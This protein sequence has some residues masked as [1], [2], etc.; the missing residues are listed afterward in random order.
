MK[1]HIRHFLAVTALASALPFAAHAADVVKIGVAGPFTG[2]N[3]AFGEQLWI[4]AT[5]AADAINSK[6]GINGKKIELIKADDACEPK[7]AVAVA[8]RL[9]D[10]D[11]V[12]AVVGHFCSSSTIPAS[13][14]YDDADILSMA[15]GSTNP[16]VTERGLP[17]VTRICGRDDQQARVVAA[18]LANNLKTKRIAVIHDKDTYGRGVADATREEAKRLGVETVLYDGVTRGERDFNALVTKIKAADVDAV[19]FGGLYAEA[20]TLARQIREQ[21]LTIPYVSDDGIVDPAFVTAAGGKQFAK[22]VYMSFP[23]DPRTLPSSKDI[24]AKLTQE[25]KKADGFVLYAY[26]A[27]EAVA[28]AI[29]ATDS[30]S[31]TELADWLKKN[32]VAT[33]LGDKEWD[34]KGDLTVPS[35]VMYQWDADGNYAELA[36]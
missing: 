16:E 24:V 18:F 23:A 32:K 31:G 9:V 30:V 1:H 20:G 4:G 33:V 2:A 5:G 14:I 35:Y 28:A 21:G 34:D 13:E 10:Q 19:F 12:A 15:T 3:A 22:G 11:K 29:A 6:G 26:S 7:Q 8:N 17:T 36:N 27:V 25:G